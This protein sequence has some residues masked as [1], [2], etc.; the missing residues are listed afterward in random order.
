MAVQSSKISE[1]DKKGAGEDESEEERHQAGG[2]KA[3]ET[4]A[5]LKA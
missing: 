5:A 4:K 3:G 1:E 2:R